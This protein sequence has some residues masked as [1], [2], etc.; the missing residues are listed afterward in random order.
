MEI[1]RSQ[2]DASVLAGQSSSRRERTGQEMAKFSPGGA[3]LCQRVLVEI[4][5][6]MG[7]RACIREAPAISSSCSMQ[8]KHVI[9]LFV[10]FVTVSIDGMVL[11]PGACCVA[12]FRPPC[13]AS[14]INQSIVRPTS[15]NMPF[16]NKILWKFPKLT[17]NKLDPVD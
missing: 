5:C 9:E 7:A 4:G 14:R 17:K 16:Q 8:A 1:V 10:L 12:V 3:S 11:R 2:L 13:Q 6:T 15:L